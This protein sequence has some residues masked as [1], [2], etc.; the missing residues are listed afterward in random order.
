MTLPQIGAVA[1][2]VLAGL[3]L[4]WLA[5][6]FVGRRAVRRSRA[7]AEEIVHG[8]S[9]L[10]RGKA[11]E[12]RRGGGPRRGLDRPHSGRSHPSS[13]RRFVAPSLLPHTLPR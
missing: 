5:N 12:R 4:G 9:V 13:L 11:T 6:S 7:E 3:L 1:A 8:G 2:S 10:G